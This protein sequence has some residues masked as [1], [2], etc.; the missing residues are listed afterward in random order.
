MANS[1]WSSLKSAA[2]SG[3]KQAVRDY[4]APLTKK[5]WVNAYYNVKNFLS[6]WNVIKL[7]QLDR[8]YQ[9][10]DVLMEEAILQLLRDFF[11][12]QQPFHMVAGVPYEKDSKLTVARH[13]ELLEKLYGPEAQQRLKDELA[14]RIREHLAAHDVE[15]ELAYAEKMYPMYGTLLDIVE[16]YEIGLHRVSSFSVFFA[17]QQ[18][19]RPLE[20]SLLIEREFEKQATARLQFV[21]ENRGHLWT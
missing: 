1:T 18:Q 19:G 12:G 11:N 16:Y 15:H 2:I 9:E 21:I 17:A 8:S 4:F 7:R 20:E 6:P 14:E 13:R 5:F 3:A 10:T